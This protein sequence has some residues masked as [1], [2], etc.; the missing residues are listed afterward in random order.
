MKRFLCLFLTFAVLFGF[1]ACSVDDKNLDVTTDAGETTTTTAPPPKV[2]ETKHSAKFKDKNGRVVYT[3]D[4]VIPQISKNAEQYI[5]D[6]V[7]KVTTEVFD[8]ACENAER[9]IE[10]AAKT[11]DNLGTDSPWSKKITFE[12]TYLSGRYVCFLMKEVFSATGEESEDGSYTTKCFDMLNG[13]ECHAMTFAVDPES[14]DDVAEF[15]IN[16]IQE[17]APYNFYADGNGLAPE[18]IELIREVFSLDNFYIT[19]TGMGFYFDRFALDSSL[20]GMYK[21]EIPWSELEGLLIYPE[22][23]Q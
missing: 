4:V 16:Y 22:A 13:T 2:K 9:N 11:M 21:T 20:S 5:I 12:S 7:N 14:R 1:A 8:D 19:E 15:A 6:Y 3:V 10:N 18:Q 23:V 17:N